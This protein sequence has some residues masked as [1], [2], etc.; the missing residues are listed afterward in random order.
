MTTNPKNYTQEKTGQSS[1]EYKMKYFHTFDLGICSALVSA[2]FEL[3]SI[4][5]SNPK[6]C[7]FHFARSSGIDSAIKNYWADELK[8]NARTL[9]DNIKA[10][11]N[12]IYSSN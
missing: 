4:D 1:S 8:I 12:R 7:E 5:K 11:K 9:V 10:I 6:K 2:D 3:I